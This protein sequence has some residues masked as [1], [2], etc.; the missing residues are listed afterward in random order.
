MS[1]VSGAADCIVDSPDREVKLLF[2][3]TLAVFLLTLPL[4]T[5]YFPQ[6]SP[7]LALISNNTSFFRSLALFLSGAQILR[8]VLSRVLV[9][10]LSW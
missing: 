8:A 2:A 5:I 10:D 3:L 6:S 1:F 9:L 7:T 4:I